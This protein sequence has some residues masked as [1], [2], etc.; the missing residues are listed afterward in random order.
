MADK[1]GAAQRQLVKDTNAGKIEPPKPITTSVDTSGTRRRVIEGPDEKSMLYRSLINVG[2]EVLGRMKKQKDRADY[3]DGFNK[4][5]D[6]GFAENERSPIR[7]AIFGPSAT[8]R[9]AQKRIIENDSRL[10]LNARMKTLEDDSKSL[11][12]HAYQAELTSQLQATLE[13]HEDP[14]IKMQIA[15]RATK[16]FETLARNHAQYRQIWIDASNV[17]AYKE[18]LSSAV[19]N[20]RAAQAHGDFDSQ[21]EATQEARH[22]FFQPLDMNTEAWLET[23][24]SVIIDH[25][26]KG[27]DLAYRVAQDQGMLDML[28]VD[29]KSKLDTAYS[30]YENKNSRKYFVEYDSLLKR[31]DRGEASDADLVAFKQAYPEHGPELNE[32]RADKS[33]IDA[34]LAEIARQKALTIKELVSGDVAFAGRTDVEQRDAVATTFG[35]LADEGLRNLRQQAYEAGEYDGDMDSGFAPEERMTYMLDN[36]A[37]FAQI[38]AMHPEVTTPMLQNLATSMISDIRREDLDEEGVKMLT[39]RFEALKQFEALDGGNFHTQFRSTEDAQMF[40][41]YSYLVHDAMY[42][43]INAI[44]ELRTVASKDPIDASTPFYKEMVNDNLDELEDDFLD[45]SPESQAF[46]GL[47]NKTPENEQAFDLEM[48]QRLSEALELFKGDMSKALPA[49][50]AAIRRNGI[51]SNGQFIPNGRKLQIKGGSVEEFIR[52]INVDEDMRAQIANSGAGFAPDVDLTSLELSINP[53]NPK[54]VIIHGR[55][56]KTGQPITLALNLPQ[57]REEFLPYGFNSFTG[58]NPYIADKDER[59]RA[60]LRNNKLMKGITTIGE[61]IG[62]AIE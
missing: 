60:F 49:A 36:P 21:V 53:S 30:I 43:P 52:G 58:Y 34:E 59:R 40:A 3:I 8:L 7:D 1:F 39:K 45:Q 9:G 23:T 2:S 38:W 14:E 25:L 54:T 18:T 5:L 51:V 4:G 44:R 6:E 37:P 27:D 62:R 12:E 35:A 47:F 46:F 33:A 13:E 41:T 50:K 55:H 29:Q 17:N 26:A 19:L 56:E 31:M 48:K 32:L 42:N 24:N 10:W 11:D 57:S 61:A 16:Q 15:E 22:M 28:D 20:M